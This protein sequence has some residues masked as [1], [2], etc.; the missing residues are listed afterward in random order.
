MLNKHKI[1]SITS[2]P[3]LAEEHDAFLGLGPDYFELGKACANKVLA[4]LE[5]EK[6]SNIPCSMMEHLHIVVNLKTAKEIGL[7]V[8]V[9][10]LRLAQVIRQ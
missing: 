2:I 9:Q 3:E 6:P 7:N 5:G 8:P 10:V 4:I 1:P